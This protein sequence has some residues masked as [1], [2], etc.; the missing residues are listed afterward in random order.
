MK[1]IALPVIRG[2]LLE[3]KE[4]RIVANE[5]MKEIWCFAVCRLYFLYSAV[6]GHKEEGI[7]QVC[8]EIHASL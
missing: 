3:I 5:F 2:R 1:I 8:L 4:T 7:I 6:S